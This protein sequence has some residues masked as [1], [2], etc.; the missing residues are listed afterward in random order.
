VA[1]D[2]KTRG[3]LATFV[4]TVRSQLS[5]EFAYQLRNVYGLDPASGQISD[6]ASLPTLSDADYQTAVILRELLEH[7]L[8]NVPT[9]TKKTSA[10]VV[11]RI[12]RE[13]AFT[14]LNRLC[15][16][17]MAEA[18]DLLIESIAKGY[19]SKGFQL[20]ARLAGHALGET[21][22]AYKT[23]LFSVFDECALDLP[24]L[25]DRFDQHGRLFPRE[26]VLLKVLDEINHHELA[27][28]WTEDET[29]GW[30]YQYFNSKEERKAMRDASQAPRNSRELA[31]RNQ[32]FT[33]RYVV[34]FLTDNT[35]GRIW[36]EMRKGKT[37]LTD[38]C[39]YLVRRPNEIFLADGEELPA[40]AEEADNADLSQEE[41]LNQPVHIPHRPLKDPREIRMLDPACGSMH[42][43]LY[44]FDLYLKIYEEF[45]D[46]VAAGNSVEFEPTDLLPLTDSYESRDE[47]LSDV[48]RLII[49][50][51]IHGIDI[52]SRAV[53]IAGLS[54]WLRAQRAWQSQGVS[55]ADRPQVRRSHIVCAEPMPGDKEQL[56]AYCKTLHPAIAQM[57]SAIFEEMKLAGEAGSLLKIEQEISSLVAKAKEQWQKQPKEKQRQL[58]G[59]DEAAKQQL[60]F[61]LSGIT[62]QQFFE[63]AEETIYESLRQYASETSEVGF[64]RKLFA[65]DAVKGFAFIDLCRK[66]FDVSLMNPP[67]GM[68]STQLE[69]PLRRKWG[70]HANDIYVLFILQVSSMMSGG[71]LQGVLSSRNFLLG[72]DQREF[73]PL[74]IGDGHITLEY[75]VDVGVGVLD[76]A[77][78][79]ACYYILGA[80]KNKTAMFCDLRSE[81]RDDISDLPRMLQKNPFQPCILSRFRGIRETP[82]LYNASDDTLAEFS[83]DSCLDPDL[84]RVTKGMSSCK[85]ERF[86]FQFWEVEPSQLT[87]RWKYC[88]KG[89]DYLW[90]V[91]NINTVVDWHLDGR[92]VAAYVSTVS[93]NVAQARRSSSY[94]FRPGATYT[95]RCSQFSLRALPKGAIFTNAAPVVI[96]NEPTRLPAVFAAFFSDKYCELLSHIEKKGKYDTGRLKM[97]PVPEC[98]ASS[99]AD[100]CWSSLSSYLLGLEAQ[101]ETSPYFLHY[102]APERAFCPS[103]FEDLTCKF[104]SSYGLTASQEFLADAKRLLGKRYEFDYGLA[105]V[106]YIFGAA[107]GR[108][109]PQ[110]CSATIADIK[111]S[112]FGELSPIQPGAMKA[113]TTADAVFG[114]DFTQ[115]P[116]VLGGVR[117]VLQKLDLDE[118]KV[119]EL[120]GR[121]LQDCITERF[122]AYHFGNYT[123]NGNE[124]PIYWPIATESGSYTLWL[125]YHRLTDQ[126]LYKA[127]NDFVDPKLKDQVRPELASLRANEARSSDQEE[128]LAELSD[129]EQE[130]EQ[131]KADLLEIAAFWKPNLNDGVQ[132]T[133][134]PL[135]KL[136]RH[137][138]WSNNL[139]KTWDELQAGNYDWANLALSIWPDRVVRE[140]CTTDRSIAIAHDLE[141]ELWE[142]VEVTKTTRGDRE[143]T[144]LEWR[145]KDLSTAEL[146]A[147]IAQ[148]KGGQGA[149]A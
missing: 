63:Q 28:L 54:L 138:A 67:F 120:T 65:G 76:G 14:V 95:Y 118:T 32:F 58:F 9:R 42:F 140:K 50:H 85:D 130:L 29:I 23:F 139:K 57:V 52:D 106:S 2:D 93:T 83:D 39:Q 127:V 105:F 35:L 47:F 74:I 71:G 56:A 27:H 16:V 116:S 3:R 60:E 66:R 18:R 94:Y 103:L 137:R 30:I 112:P 36:Y 125:Y 26:S 104:L 91:T 145:P 62:D 38:E 99:S 87:R 44:S 143:T 119:I 92:Y 109:D 55:A 61:N 64:R 34:E 24:V 73:R 69:E 122:F 78:V 101:I 21:G 133:A 82:I 117:T 128:R 43:G 53:Q 15:A 45:W 113:E 22:D 98:E 107:V 102:P 126:T 124:A 70:S 146:D 144:K 77:A 129:L 96:P 134:A 121:P 40:D 51:N 132:I 7:Y 135:W 81:D 75:L 114:S 41:L 108:W 149:R 25:F 97:L 141:D 111:L 89:A 123:K 131:F 142:E 88:A 31:V 4:G 80:R 72:R 11:N 115:N 37:Q 147:I 100:E 110:Q 20:Y 136:F 13:Q 33:P 19:Q 90:F 10:E 59:G 86:I 5:E 49:E 148:V 79:E 8:A 17:R 84:G 68:L 46:L 6:I 48:P 1:F 12:V